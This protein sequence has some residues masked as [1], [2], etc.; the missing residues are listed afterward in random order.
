MSMAC[1][2]TGRLLR[3]ALVPQEEVEAAEGAEAGEEAAASPAAGR[4]LW[5]PPGPRAAGEDNQSVRI[6]ATAE[7]S[8]G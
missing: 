1:L 6:S 4:L 3:L 2:H 5:A 8:T 7:P